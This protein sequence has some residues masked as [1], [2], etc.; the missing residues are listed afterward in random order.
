[1][2]LFLKI[3]HIKRERVCNPCHYRVSGLESEA[4]GKL[5][6]PLII[7]NSRKFYDTERLDLYIFLILPK[8]SVK[9]VLKYQD[10][11]LTASIVIE[12]QIY[13]E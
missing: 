10:H 2:G 1:M 9:I 6:R 4:V 5:M 3:K 13:R 11:F 8:L 12:P 7:C